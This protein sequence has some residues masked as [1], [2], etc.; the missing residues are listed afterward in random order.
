MRVQVTRRAKIEP[1]TTK[2]EPKAAEREQY[3]YQTTIMDADADLTGWGEDGWICY[4]VVPRFPNDPSSRQVV[5][6][7][8]R[9]K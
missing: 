8:R 7:F 5:F 3:E 6:Y 9:P 4:A 1:K 2:A